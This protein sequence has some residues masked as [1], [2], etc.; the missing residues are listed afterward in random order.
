M[1]ELIKTVSENGV[2][3]RGDFKNVKLDGFRVKNYRPF[4]PYG[5][6]FG[7]QRY[8]YD[9]EYRGD[10]KNGKPDGFGV[11][12][13]GGKNG[14]DIEYRGEFKNGEPDGF[15]V[16][17]CGNGVEYRGEFKKGEKEGQGKWIYSRKG[18]WDV[19]QKTTMEG[20][21]EDDLLKEG[22]IIYTEGKK[23][24]E[25]IGKYGYSTS[26]CHG[27][28]GKGKI[29]LSDGTIYQCQWE[30]NQRFTVERD[31]KSRLLYIWYVICDESDYPD[32]CLGGFI[33]QMQDSI[34]KSF[35]ESGDYDSD[36]SDDG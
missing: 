34:M 4:G 35:G 20:I 22:E 3:Y 29:I 2:E 7:F 27:M 13:Y 19:P 33:S 32:Y 9:I 15:G 18:L 24:I 10:F 25:Y 5:D 30:G 6:E 11:K 23:T 16:Q 14:N 8:E 31:G 1:D 26:Y 21:W 17:N 12:K 36:D 28:I